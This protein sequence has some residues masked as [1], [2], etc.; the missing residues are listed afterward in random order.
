M[1]KNIELILKADVE[2]LGNKYD[3]VKVRPGYAWNYLIP[4]GKAIL[5]TEGQKKWLAAHLKQIAHKLAQEK[6]A[7]ERI[8]RE[9]SQLTLSLHAL[10]GK[11]GKL[12]G[13]VTPTQVVNALKEKGYTV[14]RHQIRF[15]QPIR[16][17]GIHTAE[18]L[19][20]RQVKVSLQ[21]EV[22][23]ATT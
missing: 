11:D 5:A 8:A 22:I 12:F 19:L 18:V 16:T 15:P 4:Q 14:L 13:S 3:I 1:P 7:A 6:A 20:H 10:A 2:N 23:P 21:L 9:L 17:L